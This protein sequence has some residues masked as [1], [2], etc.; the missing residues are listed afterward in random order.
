[1]HVPDFECRYVPDARQQIADAWPHS[2]DDAAA[3]EEWGWRPSFNLESM[4]LD[5]L[6]RLRKKLFT[7]AFA[8]QKREVDS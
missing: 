6:E 7:I 1:V 5:M 2:L 3:R 4:T 8:A